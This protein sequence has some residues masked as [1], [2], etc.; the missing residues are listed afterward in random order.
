MQVA[1]MHFKARAHDKL[2]DALLQA[3]LKKMQGKFVATAAWRSPSSTTSRAPA[4]PGGTFARTCS[5]TST[6]GCSCSRR[7][8]RSAART[9]LWAET[10]ADVNALVL[11]IAKRHEVRKIIKAKSMVSEES[12]LDHAIEAAE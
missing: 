3:N 1:S 10:P 8:R 12:G 2:N 5:T 11:A 9:V 6:A 4:T 7:T